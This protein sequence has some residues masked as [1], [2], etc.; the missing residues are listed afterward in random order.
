MHI[1]AFCFFLIGSF[2]W[3]CIL[4]TVKRDGLRSCFKNPLVIFV[5]KKHVALHY[6]LKETKSCSAFTDVKI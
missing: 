4:E 6:K 5:R 2:L 3:K 1:K